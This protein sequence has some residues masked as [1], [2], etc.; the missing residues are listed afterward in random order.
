M[1]RKTLLAAIAFFIT[2][3][4][5]GQVTLDYYL[6][7]NSNF[8][9][10]IPTP[11]AVIGHEVGEWHVSHDKLVQ[12]MYALAEASDRVEIEEYA[13][14]HENRPLLT[15]QI[16][17]AE[18]ILNLEQMRA[19]HLK[20]SDNKQS[21]DMDLTDL[22]LVVYL[23]YSIHGNEPSGSNA[24][25][26]VAY[27]LAAA[28][29]N[30]VK[31]WLDNTIIVLDPSYN[32]DGLNRFATWVNSR[33][34]KNLVSDP[35]NTEQN[36]PWPRARTNHYWFDLNRD[37][38]P[39]QNPE[40]QGR[41]AN[42]HKWKP[43]VLTDHH[44]MG[45]NG[46]YFFQPGIPSRNNP[47]TPKNN[48]ELT[49]RIAVYHTM[50]LDEI[51]SLYYTEESF[52]DFYIGKGSS[53]PDV[54]GCVGILFEQASS[55]SHAQNSSNGILTF[56]FAI[57]NHFTTSLST[58]D[59]S[60]EM[61]VELLEH[62]RQFYANIPSNADNASIKAYLF[63][64][65]DD[66][67]K[68]RAFLTLLKSH[69]IE[70]Y[71][72]GKNFDEFD[73]TDSFIIPMKQNQYRMIQA[74]F[75]TRTQFRDSL[76]YDVSAWTL[77]LA[78]DIKYTEV[79]NKAFDLALIGQQVESNDLFQVNTGFEP[80]TYA[81]A[82]HWQDSQSPAL[83]YDVQRLGIRAKATTEPWT[84]KGGELFERGSILIPV[85]NQKLSDSEIYQSLLRLGNKHRIGISNLESGNGSSYQLGSP[86]FKSLTQPK[87]ILIVGSGVNAYEAGE[88]WHLLDQ[89]IGVA[90]PMIT[91]EK[92][93]TIDLS[94]Y[95]TLIMVGGSYGTLAQ[96]KIKTWVQ[97]GGKI[98]ATK[99]AGKWASDAGLSKVKYQ[100]IEKDS[101]RKFLPYNER[102][103]I[104]GAQKIGGA[105]FQT[106]LDLTHPLC[107]GF[108]DDLLP[109]FKRGL[110]L[111]ELAKNPYS[112]PIH[113]TA[114]P[115]LAGY[116]SD[117]NLEKIPNTPA[118]GLSA[119]GKGLIISMTDN[120]NFRGYWYGTNRLFLNALFFGGIIELG[121]AR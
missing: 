11:K 18:N 37:W 65:P 1:K 61:R 78:F 71:K 50:A 62:Q 76:F 96:A 118:V 93:N 117:E 104:N 45:T 75:E 53:Y 10:E 31:Q 13:R 105:I 43:N 85:Q 48:F 15:L 32:P 60:N 72:L 35:N 113:Y 80:S 57:R 120:P 42:Y 95:N 2:N 73:K 55:R 49:K 114:S 16:S 101:T 58:L 99:S 46:T 79:K 116:I 28:E 20:L 51:G 81:Y 64:S 92:F 22:P 87:P 29:N 30:E 103:R 74:I 68:L 17:S 14:S 83:L 8:N 106:Q 24:A 66:F 54:N 21:S 86:K 94:K 26:L 109:I 63:N 108:Q 6:P 88:V 25:L 36:E 77:P 82:F 56:P 38:L 34:S 33:R 102:E 67:S 3:V 89:R 110:Q 97:Q 90:L 119:F 19:E 100:K 9:Q 41:I 70:V 47:L 115:L 52:D 107:F 44:E 27:Y 5:S 91:Q 39:L 12:Y 111:M 40:S 98:I 121:S 84:S 59:A 4:S 23:G 7:S 112:Q 69:Q